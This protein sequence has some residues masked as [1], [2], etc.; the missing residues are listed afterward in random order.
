[1]SESDKTSKPLLLNRTEIRQGPDLPLPGI[2]RATT[3]SGVSELD[4]LLRGLTIDK[5]FTLGSTTRG[6]PVG[7][8]EKLEATQ[9]QLLAFETDD[10]TTL[11]IRSDKLA[12]DIARVRPEAV[13][14]NGEVDFSQFRDPE[15]TARGLSDVLWKTAS[16]L[17]LPHDN[18]V[19]EAKDLALEWAKKKLGEQFGQ[20]E[21]KAYDVGTTLG[22]KALMWK[23]ESRLAGRSGLYRWQEQNLTST[24]RCLPGDQRLEDAAKGKSILVLIHGTGSHTQGSFADLREDKATWDVLVQ[25]F[26]GGIFGY[27]HRTFSQSPIENAQELLDALPK[28]ANVSLL[29]HSRGGLVGDLLCLGE[30]RDEAI[31]AYNIDTQNAPDAAGLELEAQ[32]E[33]DRLRAVHTLL[34]EK[35]ITVARYVRVAC[36]ARGTRFLSDNLDV[37]LS[38]FLNLVQTGGSTLTGVVASAL[39]GPAAGESF[40]SGAS[41]ALGVLKRLVLE[42]ADK[43]IDPRMVPGIAAMR[44][45][46]PLAAFLAHPETRRHP[47]TA[48]AVI[49]GDTEFDGLG[50]SNVRRRVVNLF[51]DWRLFDQQ[52]N[53]LVVDTE[54]MYAGLAL[55]A[56]A[57]YLYD[58]DASVTHFRYFR[59]PLTRDALRDWL[60][61][62]GLDGIAPFQPITGA[63]QIPWRERDAKQA[64]RGTA[65]AGKRPVAIVIPGIMGSHIEVRGK[66]K[67]AGSGDRIWF[68]FLSLGIGKLERIADTTSDK[69]YAEDIWEKF[70]GDLADHLGKTHAVIRSPYDWRRP[71]TDCAQE[72]KKKIEQAV[73]SN[74]GQPIRL[75][76]HSMGGLVARTLMKEHPDTWQQVVDS[77]G[78]LVMLG[79]PNNGAHLMV[80]TLMGKTDSMRMLEKLDVTRDLQEILDIVSGFPGALSLLP[81]PGFSDVGT[82]PRIDTA[83]YYD[84]SKWSEIKK[85]NADRW[86]GGAICGVPKPGTLKLAETFW[87][88]ILSGNTV[89][90][91]ERVNYVFGQGKKTPCGVVHTPG[92]APKLLFTADGDG[93]VTWQSGRLDNVAEEQCWYMPVEHGDLA[94]E[95][96]YFPAIVDLL[97]RGSTEKLGRLPRRRGEASRGFILEASPPVIPGEEELARALLGSGPRRRKPSRGRQTLK[98]SVYAGDIRYLDQTVLCGHYVGD[99]ISGAELTLDEMLDG[100]LSERERLGIYATGIGTSAIVL[101]AANREQRERGSQLGAV[102]VGLGEFNGQLSVREVTET[103]RAAVLRYLLQLRD[104]LGVQAEDPVRLNSL[105]LG[106]NSTA[107]ITIAESVAAVTRGV[108]EANRQFS[109]A[110]SKSREQGATVTDLCFVELFRDAAITAAYAAIDLP[111]EMEGEL[112]RLGARIEPARTLEVGNG[113]RE[114]LS[115]DDGQGHWSRLIV[116]DPD[117]M[118]TTCPPECYEASRKLP[119]PADVLNRLC[120]KGCECEHAGESSDTAG[121]NTSPRDAS[122]SEQRYYPQRLKYVFL[123]QRARAEQTVQQ[124]QPGLIE[125]IVREQSRNPAYDAKLGRTLFQLMVPLDYKAAAREQDNLI[126]VLDKYTA[127]LPWELLQADE[128]PMAINTRMVR[129]L[130]TTRY[131]TAVRTAN[132]NA[133]CIIVAPET[134]GF[135]KRFGG[136]KPSLDDLPAA[137]REGEAVRASLRA[138][139]WDEQ[140]IAY[141]PQ[142]KTALDILSTLYQRPYR[143]LMISAHGIFEA[144]ALDGNPYSGVVLSDGLLLTAV[145]IGLMEIVPEIVFLNCCHLGGVSNAYSA[146]NRL[147]YSLANELIE[148]GVRCVVA[149]GWA[150]NDEAACTFAS[151]FFDSLTGGANF[152][153]ALYDARRAT[154]QQ[155]PGSNTWG[156]YQAYGDPSYRLNGQGERA[157]ENL[158]PYVAVEEL[159]ADLRGQR[160]Q[161]KGG[162]QKPSFAQT[163]QRIARILTKSPPEWADR[164]D[165]LQAIGELYADYGGDGFAAARDAYERALDKN[166]GASIQ[167]IEQL[168]NLESRHGE[169]LAKQGKSEEGLKLVDR[170]I[171]RLNA[172][173]GITLSG[174]AK[175]TNAERAGLLGSALKRKAAVLAEN[176]DI[177]WSTVAEVLEESAKAY[178][179]ATGDDVAKTPYNTLNALPLAWLSG[180]LDAIPAPADLASRCDATAQRRFATSKDFWDAVMSADAEMTA[181][182][183]GKPLDNPA[184]TLRKIYDEAVEK[185]PLSARQWDSVV[186]QLR[187]LVKFLRLRKAKGDAERASILEQLAQHLDPMGQVV[188]QG[189]APSTNADATETGEQPPSTGDEAPP[190]PAP[191]PRSPR[192]KP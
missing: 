79:T 1:M 96:D 179:S 116:T 28:G 44:T 192:R 153:D 152:G 187:L 170:A 135:D 155:H 105:L 188:K 130:A 172:L 59:N 66:T 58:Q 84:P 161:I 87:R 8:P 11:F 64:L 31:N 121:G 71:L 100:C 159:L 168:A 67:P 30:V 60:A 167:V 45:D 47:S 178:L 62:D 40:G 106:W 185:L 148:M 109:D 146:P 48:M 19:E 20:I 97:E 24:D 86:Y 76:A 22:A 88:D 78:R 112:K 128:E 90:N 10:G 33:R 182:L 141:C 17:M 115:A 75:L 111:R 162:G 26:P 34:R 91:P 117:A 189:S 13:N 29:T 140:S 157:L 102:I 43:R 160:E 27:E 174:D 138:A 186:T 143:V 145:E 169:K 80:H 83:K 163:S 41:S 89:V 65:D 156:A 57:H 73:A 55:S 74:P 99:A 51:C 126:V 129:Q 137:T 107:H 113:V 93:S 23:I 122:P 120:G 104:M 133:G 125:A 16:V 183:L 177:K 149:A 95:A 139:G 154:Y 35:Q 81:R 3:R 38:D 14:E 2:L 15:A 61:Q 69:V 165:V 134:Y 190:T 166:G 144:K 124:R 131:R 42:I 119:I 175:A 191:K 114:R 72:L 150:V 46:S 118:D 164:P 49:A 18:L 101:R 12:E 103:V 92:N 6:G 136:S 110:L 127:P 37:A 82:E 142:G 132:V 171:T 77:G 5:V 36:P 4:P 184:E 85:D 147:A 98:V 39:G 56:G 21:Q 70:Y 173:A 180:H 25:R 151:V 158:K 53:D 7:E 108:L 123:S 9:A 63:T 94:C 68:D 32:E 176:S 52:D 54:S 181:W 50:L